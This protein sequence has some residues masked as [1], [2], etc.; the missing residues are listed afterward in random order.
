M[1]RR[2]KETTQ[3][4]DTEVEKI[5]KEI[6]TKFGEDSV[7]TYT[8]VVAHPTVSTGIIALDKALG[9]GVPEGRMIEL[10]GNNSTGKTTISLSIAACAQK[11]YP[12]K[13]VVY[14]DAE[15]ALD[16]AW[17][18]KLGINLKQFEHCEP[19]FGEDAIFMLEAYLRS[20][21]VSVGI[22]DSVA[23]LLPEVE[24]KGDIGDANIGLQARLIAQAVRRINRMLRKASRQSIIIFINQKRAR[25]GGGPVSFAFEPSKNTGGKALPFY[26]TTRIDLSKIKAIKDENGNE[27]AQLVR[28]QVLKNKVNDGPGVRATFLINNKLGIDTAQEIL[29][30]AL[31]KGDITRAGSWY[32]ITATEEK[33]QGE[34]GIKEV[35]REKYLDKW[36]QK[37]S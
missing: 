28:A 5:R 27:T 10:F 19:E 32:Q 1:P 33:I 17:A 34:E 24:A 36:K 11:K 31:Q 3:T 35:I 2:K 23:A 26:M 13:Q 9:G 29:D 15:H 16:L 18:T 14:V 7:R 37:Y 4:Q 22:V 21:E 20:G 6:R 8:K 25:I 30:F 12:N